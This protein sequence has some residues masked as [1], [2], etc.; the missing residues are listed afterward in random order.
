MYFIQ[1]R[2]KERKDYFNE[3]LDK[4]RKWRRLV[5]APIWYISSKHK[6]FFKKIFF[7]ASQSS[8]KHFC[9]KFSLLVK[10]TV[11][12]SNFVK[13]IFPVQ[14]LKSQRKAP[15]FIER[16]FI[17]QFHRISFIVT[18]FPACTLPNA[19]SRQE[20]FNLDVL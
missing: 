17:F 18:F 13:F 7:I 6:V 19:F 15:S 4:L 8:I 1:S 14:K 3:F 16:K 11:Y 5:K 20:N 2:K 9:H 10:L 12:L